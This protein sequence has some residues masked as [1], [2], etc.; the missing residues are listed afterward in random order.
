MSRAINIDAPM[1]EVIATSDKLKA[2]ISAIEPLSPKGTRVVF[3]NAEGAAT[4]ARAFGS[5]II[6]GRV[7][8]A[9]WAQKRMN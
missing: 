8:R 2:V 7:E 6:T 5:Q 9:H 4:I 1:D 3:A